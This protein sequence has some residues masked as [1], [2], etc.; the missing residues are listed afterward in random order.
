[1]AEINYETNIVKNLKTVHKGEEVLIAFFGKDKQNKFGL[2]N[3]YATVANAVSDF[4][5]K[6]EVYMS[7]NQLSESFKSNVPRNKL[8]NAQE[9]GGSLKNENVDRYHYF[10]IDIDPVRQNSSDNKCSATDGE[11]ESACILAQEIQE[12][13]GKDMGFAEPIMAFSG[14]GYHLLYKV[15]IEA[16]EENKALF[17]KCLNVLAQKFNTDDAWVDEKIYNP[18]RFTKLYGV[19]ACKGD[20]TAERPH[21]RSGI[22][23][24]PN[25][26]EI[27]SLEKIRKLS[28]YIV[29]V[30]KNRTGKSSDDNKEK[31]DD[32]VDEML[33][34]A[35]LFQGRSDGG[36]YITIHDMNNFCSCPKTYRLND[37]RL[38]EL[39]IANYHKRTGTYIQAN[40]LDKYLDT[41]NANAANSGKVE[42]VWTRIGRVE[43][44]IYYDLKDEENIVKISKDGVQILSDFAN[45]EELPKFIRKSVSAKQ[46][47]PKK[48][49]NTSLEAL[50]KPYLNLS[51]EQITLL[52][53]AL[54]TWFI[55]DTPKVILLLTGEQG[56]GKTVL[57]KII[58]SIV[59]PVNHESVF[60]PRGTKNIGVVLASHYVVSFDNLSEISGEVSDL[61]CQV[62]TGGSIMNRQLYTDGEASILSFKNCLILNGITDIAAKP[63][64]LDRI[65]HFE[66]KNLDKK[67][68][69]EE[70]LWKAFKN[71]LPAIL[72]EIFD[73]LHKAIKEY[74]N[75]TLDFPGRMADF[76]TWGSA[77]SKVMK[78]NEKYFQ[79]AYKENRDSVALSIIENNALCSLVMDLVKKTNGSVSYFTPTGFYIA[80]I[81]I[82]SE[83]NII[84]TNTRTFPASPAALTKKL[85]RFIPVLEK[86]GIGINYYRSGNRGRTVMIGNAFNVARMATIRKLADNTESGKQMLKPTCR[87]LSD[88][89]ESDKEGRK[90]RIADL[91]ADNEE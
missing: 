84:T 87:K 35:K 82:A 27:I 81:K 55:P 17:K 75:I 66:L 19:L 34:T 13:L 71:D 6:G 2:F 43:D 33:K 20:S 25:D 79:Q 30:P 21:R 23:F 70:Q 38:R 50:L 16:N 77:I 47:L 76:E 53:I 49:N 58:Q 56:A 10:F 57:A 9:F 59:D 89:T 60:M 8:F 61:L 36:N 83:N 45:I 40:A 44:V 54:I 78:G 18:A 72:Y 91:L 48:Q 39:L 86:A 3:D 32:F 14:N 62:S 12:F 85:E 52:L 74:R 63:D 26:E 5:G 31:L 90:G 24:V 64:L 73:I 69:T 22:V 42:D 88:N 28:E 15:D 11:M 4:D 80:L 41:L 51:D 65:V 46:V 67:R 1:M 37:K 7:L 29:T 68:L